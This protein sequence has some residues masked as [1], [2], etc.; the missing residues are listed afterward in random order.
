M[1]K[2]DIKFIEEARLIAERSKDTNRKNGAVIVNDDNIVVSAG[3]NGFPMGCD[4]DVAS[5]Y[6]APAKYFYTEHAERN[7][8]FLAARRGVA[9]KGCRMY[10]TMF[11]CAD[12]AR[13]IIQSGVTKIIAPTPDV[14]HHK[15]G[16]HFKVALVMLEEA[17]VE[18]ELY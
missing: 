10:M 13:G 3:Y 18:V 12:C 7:A 17:K 5:R 2:W 6:E 14:D 15:W 9:T 11:P 1:N 8:L 4:D 16:E